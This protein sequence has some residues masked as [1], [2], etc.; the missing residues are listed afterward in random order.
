MRLAEVIEDHK[1]TTTFPTFHQGC[2]VENLQPCKQYPHWFSC[3]IQGY[4]TYILDTFIK[5]QRLQIDYNPTELT[6]AKGEIILIQTSYPSWVIAQ[7]QQGKIG[8][9]P[10]NKL[11]YLPLY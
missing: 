3:T 6:V 7:T 4:H 11:R 2:Q 9:L 8:W 1:N 5:E 10:I